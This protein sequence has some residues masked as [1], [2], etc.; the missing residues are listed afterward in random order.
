MD[1]S[2]I[3]DFFAGV[4]GKPGQGQS[5]PTSHRLG[6]T[7]RAVVLRRR[8][9]AGDTLSAAAELKRHVLLDALDER[10]L[11]DEPE[12]SNVTPLRPARSTKQDFARWSLP[13]SLVAILA[14][15][16]V[17]VLQLLPTS[18]VPS[19][20]IQRGAGELAIDST[21]PA[22][23]EQTLLQNLT[24]AGAQ[25]QAVQINDTTWTLSIEI[26]RAA[27]GVDSEVRARVSRILA[28]HG[29]TAPDA[30]SLSIVVE[31]APRH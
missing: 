31:S 18:K 7:V 20:D 1:D 25:V 22:G 19:G 29:I 30:E 13:V 6:A 23:T 8:A 24:L 11:F 4:A 14:I 12:R 9:A 28:Q 10:G 5:P 2:D 15:C 27:S 16:A 21:D 26:P 17:G 3:D